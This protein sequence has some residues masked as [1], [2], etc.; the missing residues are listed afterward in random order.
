MPIE[1]TASLWEK[2]SPVVHR[3]RGNVQKEKYQ[4]QTKNGGNR[5]PKTQNK[6]KM[7]TYM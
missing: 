6:F 5:K 2:T 3:E 4:S 1:A 7:V